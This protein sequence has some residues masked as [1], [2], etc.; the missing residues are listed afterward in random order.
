MNSSGAELAEANLS[1]ALNGNSFEL[2][3]AWPNGSKGQYTGNFDAGGHLSGVTFDI[4]HPPVRRPGSGRSRSSEPMLPSAVCAAG[5]GGAEA[6]E[7]DRCL[8]MQGRREDRPGIRMACRTPGHSCRAEKIPLVASDVEEHGNAAIRLRARRRHE[9]GSSG[10]HLQVGR[11]DILNVEEE[12]HPAAACFPTM[13]A[14][15]SPSARASSRPVAAPG[16]RTT[17]HRL[18][19]PSFVTDGESSTSSKPSALTKKLIAG[20]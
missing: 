19:R 14:W 20:S 17:T 15:S 4:A 2:T 7:A 13:A 12:T 11:V 5:S 8:R 18:G 10:R 6:H 16:G 1:G 3:V 9:L